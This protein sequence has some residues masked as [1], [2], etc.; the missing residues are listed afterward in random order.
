MTR[1]AVYFEFLPVNNTNLIAYTDYNGATSV[2]GFPLMDWIRRIVVKHN[3]EEK[4]DFAMLM[5]IFENLEEI[6]L[7]GPN[8]P[9]PQALHNLTDLQ[10]NKDVSFYWQNEQPVDELCRK[11][12]QS[13]Y[14]RK[15]SHDAQRSSYRNAQGT[16][17]PAVNQS[18]GTIEENIPR[19]WIA[20]LKRSKASNGG[21]LAVRFDPVVKTV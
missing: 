7:L 18:S 11:D 3:F 13:W 17:N 10:E 5:I 12:V 14:T 6:I 1:D 4:I 16:E 19:C 9:G 2:I 21:E 8:R 20:V 15:K